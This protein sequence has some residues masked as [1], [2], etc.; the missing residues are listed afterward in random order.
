VLGRF[1][2]LHPVK[3]FVLRLVFSRKMRKYKSLPPKDS[4]A[5]YTELIDNHVNAPQPCKSSPLYSTIDTVPYGAVR[6]ISVFFISNQIILKILNQIEQFLPF[7]K[8]FLYQCKVQCTY[9]VFLNQL[10]ID[11]ISASHRKS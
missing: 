2:F 1:L 3:V 4:A 9:L 10:V 5:V 11:V 7:S 6:L 8:H